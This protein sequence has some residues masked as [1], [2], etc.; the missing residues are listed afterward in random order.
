[1]GIEL[2]TFRRCERVDSWP[3][4]V[5]GAAAAAILPTSLSNSNY[6]LY[7]DEDDNNDEAPSEAWPPPPSPLQLLRASRLAP[8]LPEGPALMEPCTAMSGAIPKQP[9]KFKPARPP[10]PKSKKLVK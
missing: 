3:E 5:D 8:L 1:M 10:L 7:F 4:G 6:R 9:G 2:K